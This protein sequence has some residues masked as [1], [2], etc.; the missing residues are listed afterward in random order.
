MYVPESA[1][2]RVPKEICAFDILERRPTYELSGVK[3][4]PEATCSNAILPPFF[5]H[6]TN[7]TGV[8]VSLKV[9]LK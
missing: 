7:N 2:A 4:W 3:G 9:Q 6:S 1:M 8:A 5:F